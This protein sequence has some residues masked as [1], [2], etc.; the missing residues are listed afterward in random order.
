MITANI[1]EIVP[2]Q[3]L[4]SDGNDLLF[5]RVTIYDSLGALVTTLDTN[6]FTEGLYSVNWTPNTEGYYSFIGELFSD[7]LKTIPASYDKVTELIEVSSQ[8]NNILRLLGLVHQNSVVDNA[9]YDPDGNLI[10]SRLRCYD[11]AI[12]A[13]PGGSSGLLFEYEIN[14]TYSNNMMTTFTLKK[15]L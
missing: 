4:V 13:I 8:K 11:S 2:L 15:V 3:I 1:N 6:N 12:N 14:A 9:T 5:G 7:S 10:S